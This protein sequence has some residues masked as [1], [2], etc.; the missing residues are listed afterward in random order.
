MDRCCASVP[1]G[2][3]GIRTRYEQCSRVGKVERDGK[4]YCG[5]HDPQ[6]RKARDQEKMERWRSQMEERDRRFRLE[7]AAPDLLEALKAMMAQY[8]GSGVLSFEHMQ[9]ARAAI[10]KAEGQS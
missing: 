4:W 1:K 2:T 8:C 6:A 3:I 5:Q 7:K 9:L 10:A